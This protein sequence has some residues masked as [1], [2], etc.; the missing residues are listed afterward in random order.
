MDKP[1]LQHYP[2]G[3]PAEIELGPEATLKH[4]ID[5]CFVEFRNL[6][7]FTNMGT[8]LT[9]AEV[10]QC[11]RYFAAWLQQV[12]GLKRGD[13]LAVMLP[14]ILQYPIVLYGALRSGVTVVNV[15]P[16]YTPRELEHQLVD[17]GATA[18]VVV[19]NFAHTLARVLEKTAVKTVVT[20]RIGDMLRTP[21]RQ[22]VNFVVKYVQKRV[23]A[24]H[25]PGAHDL[26][27]AIA[28]GKWHELTDVPVE[29]G[30]TA[31][32][33]YTGG[34]TGVSKGAELQELQAVTRQ[35]EDVVHRQRRDHDFA[36]GRRLRTEPRLH[37]FEVRHHVPMRELGA[38]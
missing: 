27:A 7:A 8:T 19:E 33:Q 23:P 30:D 21:K 15:N 26:R 13:R 12:A 29:P 37:L 9:F 11:S 14:N 32:L 31:F 10:D 17:S 22:L 20:T 4:V 6:P 36:A 24:W 3:V 35:R 5:A 16:L 34:T 2:P 25:I 18:I 1:W 38:L 28:A